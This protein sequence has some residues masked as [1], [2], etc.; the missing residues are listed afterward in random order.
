[1]IH[2]IRRVFFRLRMA[3]GLFWSVMRKRPMILISGCTFADGMPLTIPPSDARITIVD[4]VFNS[5]PVVFD[6]PVT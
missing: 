4:N 3:V 1:M 2:R 5:W 6:N